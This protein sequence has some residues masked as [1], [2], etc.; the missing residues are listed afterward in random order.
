MKTEIITEKVTESLMVEDGY[1]IPSP[2]KDVWKVAV[3]DRIFGSGKHTLAFL[4]NFGAKIGAFASTWNFHE[5][6]LIVIV[7]N[8]FKCLL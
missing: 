8:N 2:D 5:N 1:V 7:K 6:N 3:I 4:K